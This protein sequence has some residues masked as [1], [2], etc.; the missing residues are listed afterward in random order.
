MK[1]LFMKCIKYVDAL[2]NPKDI[3]MYSYTVACHPLP[4]DGENDMTHKKPLPSAPT[5][6]VSYQYLVI[7]VQMMCKENTR[8]YIGSG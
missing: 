7:I 4:G 3:I 5:I 2:V 8:V 1:T 6:D